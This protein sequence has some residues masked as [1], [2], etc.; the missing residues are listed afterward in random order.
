VRIGNSEIFRI[1]EYEGLGFPPKEHLPNWSEADVQ[2]H[3]SWMV[4][5]HFAPE[6]DRLLG[7][8]HSWLIRRA[9]LTILIDTCS[10]NG[11]KRPHTP[12]FSMLETGYLDEFKALGITPE[13]IDYVL[14][15]HLHVDHVGW[16][17][18]SVAG[19]WLPTFPNAKYVMSRAEFEAIAE[20]EIDQADNRAIFEDSL[21]PILQSGQL[22][23]VD[24]PTEL[25]DGILVEPAPG[26]TD[27]HMIL[28][29]AEIEGDLLFVG[30]MMHHPVQVWYPDW[31]SNACR[32]GTQAIATRR[33]VLE[34]SS[35]TS[36]TL[37]PTHFAKP[38]CCRV[39][40]PS[41]NGYECILDFQND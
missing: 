14:C 6:Q 19:Q 12:F 7:S 27:G 11:K 23:L 33:A 22:M 9:G 1:G 24:P 29:V 20:A 16:N 26:H 30:D 21:L 3:L 40:R 35:Q 32:N 34:R 39:G 2:M 4:P 10:G 36:A 17:T 5:G 13:E 18:Q 25:G 8:V 38:Y 41:G 15:T 37:F 31:N 28:R